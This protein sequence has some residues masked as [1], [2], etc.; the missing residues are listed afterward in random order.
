MTSNQ[1][2]YISILQNKIEQIKN[3]S[4]LIV[5][6][7]NKNELNILLPDNQSIIDKL[8]SIINKACH[9]VG[10][11][12]STTTHNSTRFYIV[13]KGNDK[14]HIKNLAYSI[15]YHTQLY[16]NVKFPTIYLKCISGSINFNQSNQLKVEQ[17]ISYLLHNMESL[18]SYNY[19]CYEDHPVNIEQLR[20]DNHNLYLLKTALLQKKLKFM[21]QPVINSDTG[22]IDYH[23]CLL[24][25]LDQNGQFVSIGPMIEDAESKGLITIV[26]HNVVEMVIDQL[27]QDPIAV[28]SINISNMGVLN[29][30]LLQT[31]TKLL[32]KYNVAHRLIIEITETS[33]NQNFEATKYFI[34]NVHLH[35]CRFALDDFGS[36]FTFFKQLSHLPI[37]IIKI[38]GNYIRDILVNKQSEYFVVNLINLAHDLGIKTVAEFVENKEIAEMLTTLKID[39]M[40]GNFFSPAVDHRLNLMYPVDGNK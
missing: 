37:D 4:L 5:K 29:R 34:D 30:R 16:V 20:H 28:L 1:T 40:Q 22:D 33:L 21:Y 10:E 12:I 19:Y 27:I 39:G 18:N 3:G 35:G 23:E 31:I 13:V 11:T 25:V 2:K 7:I 15:F 17:L 36:G 14:T 32:D 8:Y 38:D 6:L 24:R 9:T 26:D